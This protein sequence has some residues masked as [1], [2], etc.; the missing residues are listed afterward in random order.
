MS[1]IFKYLQKQKNKYNQND[2]TTYYLQVIKQIQFEFKILK[3][4]YIFKVMY[5]NNNK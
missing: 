4:P 3:I 2:K 1:N 5:N